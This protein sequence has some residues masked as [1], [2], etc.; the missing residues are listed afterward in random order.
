VVVLG[1]PVS[2][3]WCVSDKLAASVNAPHLDPE[4]ILADAPKELLTEVTKYQ[5][6]NEVIALSLH[7]LPPLG[8]ISCLGRRQMVF[9][10]ISIYGDVSKTGVRYLSA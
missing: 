10:N 8:M 7:V 5:Q 4:S 9:Q 1:P 2:G 6:A 3:K